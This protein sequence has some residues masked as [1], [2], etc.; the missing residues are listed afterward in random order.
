MRPETDESFV[1]IA[2]LCLGL[3]AVLW[4][5]VGVRELVGRLLLSR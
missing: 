4:F 3:V 5:V 2:G 1:A